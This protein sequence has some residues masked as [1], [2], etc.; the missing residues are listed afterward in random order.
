MCTVWYVCT[1]GT[2]QPD[3]GSREAPPWQWH[4]R[5]TKN[6]ARTG[7]ASR[8]QPGQSKSGQ[9]YLDCR[10]GQWRLD[11]WT[12]WMVGTEGRRDGGRRDDEWTVDMARTGIGTWIA[13][14]GD[15]QTMDKGAEVVRIGIVRVVDGDPRAAGWTKLVGSRNAV[16]S[17][18][19]G[20]NW[21]TRQG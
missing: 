5:L 20:P 11:G 12:C 6:Q 8:C 14:R 7:Q 4:N 17:R 13:E 19:V 21:A 18:N 9:G 15:R 2:R 16:I 1:F 3:P 10:I